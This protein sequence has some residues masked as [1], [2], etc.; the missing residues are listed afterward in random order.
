MKTTLDLPE[1]LLEEARRLA[2]ARTKREAI[3]RALESFVAAR[4]RENLL[5]MLGRTD[6]ALAREEL[7]RLRA[8]DGP[9]DAPL[10]VAV[11]EGAGSAAEAAARLWEMLQGEATEASG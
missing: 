10:A 3:I 6:V 1:E 8:D 9:A 5:A 4:R 2:G 11:P 7:E